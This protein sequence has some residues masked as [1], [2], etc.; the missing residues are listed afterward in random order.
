[1]NN[2]QKSVSI[3]F[4]LRRSDLDLKKLSVCAEIGLFAEPP[5][6]NAFKA[7]RAKRKFKL[8]KILSPAVTV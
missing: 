8:L 3:I 5:V 1:M 2:T 6:F 7:G 4:S